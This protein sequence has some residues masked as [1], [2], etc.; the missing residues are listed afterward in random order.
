MVSRPGWHHWAAFGGGE[1]AGFGALFVSGD[2]GWLG[3]AST[4]A[5]HRRRGS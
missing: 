2:L 4:R 3:F 1:P 5:T